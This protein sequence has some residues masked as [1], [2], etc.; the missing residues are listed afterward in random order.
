VEQS[1][2]DQGWTKGE[3]ER[4]FAE[5][6]INLDTDFEPLLANEGVLLKK[7]NEVAG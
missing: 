2:V 1:L 7:E 3:T 4:A 6:G 5:V